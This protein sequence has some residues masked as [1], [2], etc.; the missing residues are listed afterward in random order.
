MAIPFHPIP[1]I[2]GFLL[3]SIPS[4]L[5]I[6]RARGVDLRTVGSGNI[7]AT[8]AIRGLGPRWGG[9]VFAIDTAKGAVAALLGGGHVPTALAAGAAAILGHV[10]SPWARFKGGR[11][12]ATSLGV[13][14]AIL[15]IPALLA[16]AVWIVLFA[17]SRRVSVGS[18]GAAIAY[19]L[20][21]LWLAPHDEYRLARVVAGIL[22]ALLVV[23]RH[24]PNIRRL[25]AGTEAPSFG[26]KGAKT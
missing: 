9:L 12:V 23:I 24:I 20:L 14:L 15:P 18:L 21:V 10:F 25:A 6:A 26:G 19:P 16:L 4:G 22:V 17:L 8:N 2:L 1:V 13:F 11:G 5:W 7:G 3:G